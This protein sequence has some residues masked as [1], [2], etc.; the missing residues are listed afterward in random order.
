MIKKIYIRQK[1]LAREIDLHVAK[2]RL[3]ERRIC[4]KEKGQAMI[5]QALDYESIIKDREDVIYDLK[6]QHERDKKAYNEYKRDQDFVNRK[7]EDLEPLI[8][9]IIDK[10]IEGFQL[11]MS[12]KEQLE[13]RSR[14]SDGREKKIKKLL[15]M[16]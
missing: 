7:F 11:F 2:G 1:K 16:A 9:K 10:S 6:K 5:V 12:E 13:I 15:R 3:K 14:M 4:E 8:K